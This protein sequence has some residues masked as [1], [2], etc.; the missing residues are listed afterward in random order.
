LLNLAGNAIKFTRSGS[1][2]ILVT[3]RK[4]EAGAARIRFRVVDTGIGVPETARSKM[5]GMFSQAD[6]TT[7]RRFGG[8]GL[9]L[10][11]C[12][13][14]VDLLGGE[15]GYESLEGHGSTFWFEVP[16]KFAAEDAGEQRPNALLGV[17]ILVVD[18]N[19][20]NRE[21]L[22][23]QTANWGASVD[24]AESAAP[25]LIRIREA[26]NSGKPYDLVLLDH[27]MPGM[28]GLELASVLRADPSC[29][30]T[31]LVMISSDYSLDIRDV[32]NGLFD[33]ILFKPVRQAALFDTLASL[34]GRKGPAEAVSEAAC[35]AVAEPVA[36]AGALRI[37]L[38]EDIE[39]NQEVAARL[40][41]RLGHKVDV[42][43]NGAEALKAAQG[44]D[45]DVVLMDVQMPE[46]DGMEATR[47]IRALPSP[48]CDV[49][50]IAM[51]AAAMRGDAEKCLEVG[52]NGYV[53]KPIDRAKLRSVLAPYVAG[54]LQIR[55]IAHEA[56]LGALV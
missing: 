46:M 48:A 52:M 13:R 25:G 31:K 17:R 21:V 32:A 54:K 36:T 27:Q 47:A 45:Y 8:T 11:I 43:G 18:D 35:V 22:K 3:L 2:S 4:V 40:L 53:S 19:R 26:I 33:Q 28:I 39:V 20:V 14:I 49:P 37:L 44:G 10:A 23:R 9:G 6:S 38:A 41:A 50:I 1:V 30:S 7:S 29:A 42:V 34:L 24:L 55:P 5:F 51:T 12:K 56:V 15:I 16:L